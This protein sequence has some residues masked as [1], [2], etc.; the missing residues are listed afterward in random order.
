MTFSPSIPVNF[1][2]TN[3]IL[4]ADSWL[5]QLDTHPLISC[6]FE[7]A[8]RY[9]QAD[10]DSFQ[11]II[12]SPTSTHLERRS[13]QAKLRATALDH[14]SHTTITHLSAAWS[15][16]DAY[17]FIIDSP[18]LLRRIL[19]WLTTTT[20]RQIWHNA[21]YDFRQIH[22]R[23]G[24]FPL[25]YEDSQLLAKCILNHV[26]T[27]K[28]KSGLKDL[29]AHWFGDWGLSADN[30]SLAQMYEPHVLRYAATDACA[31]FKLFSSMQSYLAE[32]YSQPTYPDHLQA[33]DTDLHPESIL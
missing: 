32:S 15:E 19:T 4:V 11:S 12:D 13:A 27:F 10:L 28:A 21:S 23:T 31:T 3:N 17:V 2:S 30:F 9:T 14:P 33:E 22:Y 6:D 8:I 1:E 26:E 20:T 25:N 16:S 29:A 5:R 18:K 24:K 7:V